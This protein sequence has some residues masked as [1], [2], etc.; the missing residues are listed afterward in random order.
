M[1]EQEFR[2]FLARFHSYDEMGCA[3]MTMTRRRFLQAAGGGT[4]AS[5]L[6]GCGGAG[7]KGSA[8]QDARVTL[9]RYLPF[10]GV[11]PDLPGTAAG[12]LPG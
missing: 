2:P 5:L 12:I 3:A 9:P 6:A 7:A 11:R 8:A 4:A 1:T 10:T